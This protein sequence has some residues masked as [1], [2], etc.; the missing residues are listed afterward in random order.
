MWKNVHPVHSAGIQAH[1]LWNMSL[2]P[3][4]LDQG[5][6]PILISYINNQ[7]HILKDSNRR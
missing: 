3:K 6:R 1:D 5:F 7:N 4:P 2:F